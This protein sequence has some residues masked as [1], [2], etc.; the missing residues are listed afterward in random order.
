MN[1]I[2]IMRF[3]VTQIRSFCLSIS[4]IFMGASLSPEFSFVSGV[5]SVQ[6]IWVDF[7]LKEASASWW[8]IRKIQALQSF[9]EFRNTQ[10]FF[11]CQGNGKPLTYNRPKETQLKAE[12][13]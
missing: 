13:F 10:I 5:Q 4:L 6:K 11:L 12:N 8:G 3:P 7:Q 1:V 9:K 2:S